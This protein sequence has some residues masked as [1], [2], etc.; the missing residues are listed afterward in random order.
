METSGDYARSEADGERLPWLETVEDDHEERPSVLRIV[1]L[2]L[3][4]LA[5]LAAAI[6]AFQYYQA[7][8]GVSGDGALIAAQEGDYKVKPDDPGGTKVDGEGDTAIATS[9]GAGTGNSSIDMSRT[10]EKP[11][12]GKKAVAAVPAKGG[13]RGVTPIPAAAGAGPNSEKG[14][15]S[16]VQLGSF[17]DEASANAAWSTTSKRLAFLA[18]LGKSVQ[19]AQVGGK[20]MYRLRVNAGSAGQASAVCDRIKAAGEV[21]FVPRS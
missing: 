16:L 11:I 14:G 8:R 17:P 6:F 4:A 1:L 19:A 3:L 21:C 15:G 2:V 18:P 9:N 5:I 20:T 13:T 12:A 7:H 10:A